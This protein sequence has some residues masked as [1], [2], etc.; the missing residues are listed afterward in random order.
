M[1]EVRGGSLSIAGAGEPQS[2]SL[3]DGMA[4]RQGRDF[5]SSEMFRFL[6]ERSWRG[7]E[8]MERGWG[9]DVVNSEGG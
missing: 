3:Q 4:G 1:R 5:C 7:G 2:R 9:L 8:G 6:T